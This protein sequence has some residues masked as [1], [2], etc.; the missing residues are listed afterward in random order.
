MACAANDTEALEAI[1]INSNTGSGLEDN[2][3]D[4]DDQVKM[5]NTNK[6][7]WPFYSDNYCMIYNACLYNN[8]FLTLFSKKKRKKK[9]ISEDN[10]F[11]LRYPFSGF[12]TVDL[13]RLS[14]VKYLSSEVL[15]IE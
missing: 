12:K 10:W 8:Y 11:I 7:F 2:D 6:L 13:A 3:N 1:S 14:V 4:N 15:L 5:S 9:M